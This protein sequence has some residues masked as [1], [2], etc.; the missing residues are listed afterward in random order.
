MYFSFDFGRVNNLPN[1]MV[2]IE[3][4][5]FQIDWINFFSRKIST[6]DI[7]NEAY[8]DHSF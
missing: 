7:L 3:I 8:L 6:N 1:A 4:E 2:F 5:F